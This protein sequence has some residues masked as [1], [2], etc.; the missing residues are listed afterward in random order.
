[1]VWQFSQPCARLTNHGVK[2]K[3]IPWCQ[4]LPIMFP[5]PKHTPLFSL[6]KPWCE[7][8]SHAGVPGPIHHAPP[9]LNTHLFSFNKPW[10]ELKAMPWCTPPSEEL[11]QTRLNGCQYY[12]L[13]SGEGPD[14]R[15]S[16]DHRIR[17]KINPKPVFADGSEPLTWLPSGT[18]WSKLVQP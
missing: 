7:T 10:Y 8:K 15:L 4:V 18:S 13:D 9:F 6:N 2:Q 5:C 11:I 1:M 17:R 16:E 3:D 12:S 14:T